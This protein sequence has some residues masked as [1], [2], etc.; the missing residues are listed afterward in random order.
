MA[1]WQAH[2]ASW[3]VRLRLKRRLART[4]DVEVVRRLFTP[5]P[6]RVPRDVRITPAE[7]GGVSGE[8]VEQAGP[9]A[10]VLLFL[11]GGGYFACSS[12]THRAVTVFY[13]QQ[14]FRV[15]APDC[16]LAPEHRFPA[17][18][19]DALAVYRGLLGGASFQL[20][21]PAFEP[22]SPRSGLVLSGESAGGGLCLAL[23]LALRD[24]GLPLPA[25]AALFSPWTD[26]TCSGD[27]VRTNHR[28]CSMLTGS[29]MLL[30]AADYLASAD[31]RNPLASPLF[32]DLR[33]LPPLLVHVG[34]NEVL[35]DDSTRLAERARAAGVPVDL[36][37]FPVVAH[38]WQL[39]QKFVPEARESLIAA[40]AFLRAALAPLGRRGSAA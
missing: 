10:P 9:G 36:R 22:A 30:A 20:A 28:R 17:A 16:R 14:G 13:A 25:A 5:P 12:V 33:G 37:V 15:F 27:S 3:V 23:M 6:F 19:D 8:W 39:G 7:I 38:A 1:S 34:A 32:A 4:R 11:H 35:L 2:V 40:S 31:P 24:A 18:V 21:M 29:G 26:L